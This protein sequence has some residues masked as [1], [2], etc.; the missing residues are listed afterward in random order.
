MIVKLL[1]T[2]VRYHRGIHLVGDHQY[3]TIAATQCTCRRSHQLAVGDCF[4]ELGG[5]LLVDAMPEACIHHHRDLG[6]WILLHEGK[7]CFIQ[8]FQ[9]R[10]TATL[11]GKVA[12]VHHYVAGIGTISDF[13]L[14]DY[15]VANVE[16]IR[17]A[18]SWSCTALEPVAG[19]PDSTRA[20]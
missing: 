17:S 13:R 16:S 7:H 18:S 8:L 3:E 12:S 11:G 20:A 1:V 15:H 9:A 10:R 14:A 19:L 6:F 2:V 4:G 5:F